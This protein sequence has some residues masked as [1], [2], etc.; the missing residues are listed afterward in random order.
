M[1]HPGGTELKRLNKGKN[2][3]CIVTELNQKY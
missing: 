1:Q 2:S 3:E